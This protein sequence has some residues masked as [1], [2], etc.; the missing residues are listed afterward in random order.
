MNAPV[1]HPSALATEMKSPFPKRIL[2]VEDEPDA[3]EVLEQWCKARGCH[4]RVAR[5]GQEALQISRS[6]RP[7]LLIADYL[8]Q[9]EITGVDV[10]AHVRAGGAKVR[11]VLITGILQ[12]ALLEAAHRLHRIPILAKPFD[13]ERLGELLSLTSE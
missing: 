1:M 13:F 10:I 11:C 9:D 4:V 3:L 5:T 8:L 7:E 12:S 2:I 6:F